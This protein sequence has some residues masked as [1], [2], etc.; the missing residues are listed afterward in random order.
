V[1][2]GD[3]KLPV[4]QPS[5][6][7]S[8]VASIATND[9]IAITDNDATRRFDCGYQQSPLEIELWNTGSLHD[10]EVG[11]YW[12]FMADDGRFGNRGGTECLP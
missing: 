10:D 4:Y 11:V 8:G 3:A 5:A 7:D 1:K 12:A 2:A 6:Q 9:A